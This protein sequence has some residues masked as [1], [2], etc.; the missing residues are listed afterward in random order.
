MS[1]NPLR[2]LLRH[3]LDDLQRHLR[4]DLTLRDGGL[5]S[6]NGGY[7]VWLECEGAAVW[8]GEG[9]VPRSANRRG[10]QL[11]LADA[12]ADVAGRSGVGVML[13]RR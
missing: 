10:L 12:L 1:P 7:A 3:G 8:R 9:R 5:S 11:A 4:S 2:R 13:W 6:V